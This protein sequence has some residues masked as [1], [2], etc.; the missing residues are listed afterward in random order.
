MVISGF[1]FYDI[2]SF[3]VFDMYFKTRFYYGNV[4]FNVFEPND[5]QFHYLLNFFL[6]KVFYALYNIFDFL[7]FRYVGIKI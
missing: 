3:K 2:L 6:Q 5:L 7:Y 1:Y 4:T